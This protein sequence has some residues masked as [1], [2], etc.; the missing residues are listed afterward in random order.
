MHFQTPAGQRFKGRVLFRVVV[1]V[2]ASLCHSGH[3][4]WMTQT[5]SLKAGWNS[6]YLH[7]DAS[8]TNAHSLLIGSPNIQEVWMWTADL[9][10]GLTLATPPE[11]TPSSRWSQWTQAEGTNSGLRWL[12]GNSA[13]LVKVSSS[14]SPFTW[15]IKGKPVAPSY[16]WTL[17]GLN[18]V[19]LPTASP[20]PNFETFLARDAQLLDWKQNAEIFRYQGGILG[21]TNPL[22]VSAIL[23]RNVPVV[24]EQAYWIRGCELTNQIYNHYFGPFQITGGGSGGLRFGDS[25]GQARLYLRNMTAGSLTVTLREVAS[26][27]PP[28]GPMP[29]L[30]PLLVRGSIV[31]SNLTFSYSS[32]ITGP[33]QWTLAP[34]GQP[35]SEIEIVLGVDR[36][37][38]GTAAG[39]SFA[40]VLRFT[41]SLGLLRVD[42]GA[43]ATTSSRAGLW[44]GNAI[45]DQVSQELKPYTRVTNALEFH[46][47][48]NQLGLA[49][50]TNNP[51]GTNVLRFATSLN[52][53]LRYEWDTN[54]GRVLVFGTNA[55]NGKVNKGSYLLDGPIR[56]APDSVA[57]P[58]PLRLIVHNN[59]TT[60]K[61]MQ[62]VY[63]GR[64]KTSNMV[65]AARQSALLSADLANAR[66][67][68]A[69]H[70]P[71]S[72]GIGPWDFTG[73]ALREGAT[74]QTI[75][76]L[77]YTDH[78]SN[79]F[80]HTYHP[81][82]DNRDALYSDQP[83][84]AGRESYGLRRVMRL[85]FTSPGTDFEGRTQGGT[86][87]SGD[88]SETV[89]I[90]G[91]NN[92]VLKELNVLGSFTLTRI[93]DI[94]DY[95]SQ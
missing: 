72:D 32:L 1:A 25:Q 91:A 38:M 36:S 55:G 2:A 62:R 8:H 81:D 71:T 49:L 24:R 61:L 41:D 56:T 50:G 85:S 42:L 48:L 44:V 68:S 34:S 92:T 37:Q 75:I 10:P 18:F 43:S 80:L 73:G 20:A 17:T 77:G 46:A 22:Q 63:L 30:L 70:L 7:V 45:V 35:G 53:R 51:S 39:A 23:Q 74:L 31:R 33:S 84:P 67:L 11:P 28:T 58:F 82:H 83:L 40:G 65:V 94:T 29:A 15:N 76:D 66:R 59:G 12:Q 79:P 87:L 19:G 21:T 9:P 69:V 14:A 57:R 95:A 64:G 54:T 60:A 78:A 52:G 4:Q 26:E 93:T 3:A 86:S 27:A 6:I 47:R 89:S 90:L 16:R 13:L 5:N 88:Y